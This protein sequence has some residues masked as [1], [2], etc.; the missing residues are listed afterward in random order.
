MIQRRATTISTRYEALL[1][2][3]GKSDEWLRNVRGSQT[4]SGQAPHPKVQPS[5]LGAQ[6]CV[7]MCHSKIIF[8]CLLKTP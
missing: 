8:A 3:G 4:V 5:G 2:A 6:Y 1:T 7:L